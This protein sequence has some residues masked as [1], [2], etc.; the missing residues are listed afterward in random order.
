MKLLRIPVQ[1]YTI[2]RYFK[3]RNVIRYA[4]QSINLK[5]TTVCM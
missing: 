2:K 5:K 3:L 4:K 1:R